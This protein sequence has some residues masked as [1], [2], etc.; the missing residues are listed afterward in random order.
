MKNISRPN[1]KLIWLYN[2]S[3]EILPGLLIC[4]LIATISF[5]L[6]EVGALKQ[7]SPSIIAV[8][9]GV[10]I[11]NLIA[12]PQQTNAGTSFSSKVLV[13]VAVA[14]L[15]LQISIIEL[16]QF[17]ALHIFMTILALISSFVFIK[18]IGKFLGV[19]DKLCELIAAGTSICGAAAILGVNTAT[20]AEDDDVAYAIGMVTIFGTFSMLLYPYLGD[21]L[22]LNTN[23]FGIWSGIS[24]HEV[25][26]VVGAVSTKDAETIHI[27]TITK[28]TR[29]L[30]LAPLVMLVKF[31][32]G[33]GDKKTNV[34]I[35]LF[36]IA[37]IV[38]IT[39][40][41]IFNIPTTAKV[42]IGKVSSFLLTMA[43][44]AMGLHTKFNAISAKGAKPLILSLI[45]T[46]YISLFGLVLIEFIA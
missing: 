43:L 38:F 24:I 6:H 29:V 20:N 35:P 40:A 19:K 10:V 4:L 12:M 45:G 34:T 41:N 27:A 32:R 46:L 22:R 21:V 15:G 17:G 11:G 13:R 42:E 2:Q 14:L 39:L 1:H 18:T 33:S 36:V 25:A 37:F 44:A 30:M 16:T 8:I 28:L 9:I 5:A 23:Q 7:F 26:Q 31:T 3:L